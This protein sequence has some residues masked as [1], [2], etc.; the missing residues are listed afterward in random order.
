MVLLPLLLPL[1]LQTPLLQPLRAQ[2]MQLGCVRAGHI[3]TRDTLGVGS[4]A[5]P[6][7]GLDAHC[8]ALGWVCT[9]R[10][11]VRYALQSGWHCVAAVSIEYG[12]A[13]GT[14]RGWVRAAVGYAPW[15]S[16]RQ[17][18]GWMCATGRWV[19]CVPP[20]I[21]SDARCRALGWVRAGCA[22][23]GCA[24]Q[25][26]THHSWGCAGCWVRCAPGIGLSTRR[27]RAGAR[28][29][30]GNGRWARAACAW[31]DAVCTRW[32]GTRWRW[33][34]SRRQRQ[35]QGGHQCRK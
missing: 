21:R 23:V 11:A 12:Q 31:Q 24:P 29:R 15:L 9:G 10:A 2:L 20:G 13:L 34:Q 30:A 19:G 17:A 3:G 35:K 5:P 26:G 8:R 1:L 7:V 32:A 33:K 4:D 27:V 22:V 25:L 28:N 18:L 6:G 14:R 16:M